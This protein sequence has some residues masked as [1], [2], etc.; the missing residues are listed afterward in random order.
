MFTVFES[1]RSGGT[2]FY[3]SG[4]CFCQRFIQSLVQGDTDADVK[5][6]ADERQSQVL[7]RC[8][9]D[10]YTESAFD[11]FSGFID[12]DRMMDDPLDDFP[13]VSIKVMGSNPVDLGILP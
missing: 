8:F 2:G 11:A 1:Q 4:G 12:N 7:A 10:A 6:P 9:C 13:I 3:A 5:P